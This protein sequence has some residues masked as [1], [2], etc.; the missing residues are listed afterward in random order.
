MNDSTDWPKPQVAWYAVAVLL[1]AYTCSFIDRTI[2]S[3]LVEPI[4]ADLGLSDTEIGMLHGLAFALFYT[5]MGIP[6]AMLADRYSRR[7]IIA[8]GIAFWSIATACCGLANRFSHLFIARV[9]VGVGEAA[10]SPAAFSLLAD[11][12][13]AQKIGRALSVYSTGVFLGAGLAFII[14]GAVI[15][16]IKGS[17]GIIL[18]LVGEVEAWQAAFIIVGLPGLLLALLVLTIAEP[19]RRD[20]A[21][22]P[23][24]PIRKVF[25][26]L[27]EHPR[28]FFCHFLG[29]ALL[30]AAFNAVSGWGP[31]FLQRQFQ[32]DA[33]TAGLGLGVAVLVFGTAGLLVGGWLTD[34]GRQKG[35][36][37]AALRVG[38]LSG[39]GLIP[40]GL[41][42]TGADSVGLAV[43]WLCPFMFFAS[44]S[45]G[46]A[47]AAIQLVAPVR[48]RAV[49]SAL[50]LF[51]NNLLGIGLGPMVVALVTDYVFVDEQ[52]L[53]ASIAWVT[54]SMGVLAALVLYWGL[55][56]YRL[57]LTT[58]R[59]E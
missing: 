51:F 42:A 5:L 49:V 17:D 46:G 43:L 31:A 24:P 37:D 3:L 9:G 52:M 45:F 54:S 30:S 28:L 12:F 16:L 26:Y 25:G 29:F 56:P 58:S 35:W 32:A 41:L 4:K 23:A 44:M 36:P 33:P 40:F 2:L 39:L 14:G 15:G 53:S 47:A 27:A 13:P 22:T 1:L 7:T 57:A 8:S 48:M 59:G 50:Y 20:A 11:S 19:A 55:R 34:R 21:K 18:P 10:L 6:I 38:V